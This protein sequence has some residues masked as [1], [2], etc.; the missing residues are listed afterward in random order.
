VLEGMKEVLSSSS[1]DR[2]GTSGCQWSEKAELKAYG[3][4]KGACCDEANGKNCGVLSPP[5]MSSSE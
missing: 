1:V 5:F 2:K 3:V 4:M